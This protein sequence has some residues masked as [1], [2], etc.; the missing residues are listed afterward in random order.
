MN[1]YR[2]AL[3]DVELTTWDRTNGDPPGGVFAKVTFHFDDEDKRRSYA[4]VVKEDSPFLEVSAALWEG[5]VMLDAAQRQSEAA[6][7]E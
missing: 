5:S 1:Q 3:K 7:G 4:F 2:G 6:P